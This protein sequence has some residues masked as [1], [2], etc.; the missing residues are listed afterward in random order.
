MG[1]GAAASDTPASSTT[2]V[3]RGDCCST[4]VTTFA[5]CKNCADVCSQAALRWPCARTLLSWW[6][7]QPRWATQVPGSADSH[8][9]QDSTMHACQRCRQC[10]MISVPDRAVLASSLH[11]RS[12]PSHLRAR[13]RGTLAGAACRRHL[14]VAGRRQA[15]AWRADAD[16]A[17]RQPAVVHLQAKSITFNV[18]VIPILNNLIHSCLCWFP[19]NMITAPP[20]HRTQCSDTL[21]IDVS[22]SRPPSEPEKVDSRV[23]HHV[24][25]KAALKTIFSCQHP[26]C[27]ATAPAARGG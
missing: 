2:L 24:H 23:S 19:C 13:E 4:S 26:G 11:R 10:V 5:A 3:P 8:S 17:E 9:A 6:T 1:V 16:D 18:V 7:A 20:M 15:V 27:D 25:T 21:S 12:R 22:R 14:H